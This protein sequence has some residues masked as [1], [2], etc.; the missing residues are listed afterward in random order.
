MNVKLQGKMWTGDFQ[1][2]CTNGLARK[3]AWDFYTQIVRIIII[4]DWFSLENQSAISQ[5]FLHLTS[6]F[7]HVTRWKLDM[8]KKIRYKISNSNEIAEGKN[9]KNP[10]FFV[11]NELWLKRRKNNGKVNL[12]C[13]LR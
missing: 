6:E 2:H 1:Q 12:W 7:Q 5:S 11:S 3:N 10:I 8:Q 9:C 13:E 4:A